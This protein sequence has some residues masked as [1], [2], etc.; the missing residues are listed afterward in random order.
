[1][2]SKSTPK[3]AALPSLRIDDLPA[4]SRALAQVIGLENLLALA[5][6]L[7]G[8]RIYIP[9]LD[10]LLRQLKYRAVRREFNGHNYLQLSLKYGYTKRWIREIVNQ[11]QKT[12]KRTDGP[13]RATKAS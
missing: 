5:R 4:E 10:S 3:S 8:Q 12:G 9:I 7:G 13:K 6:Q 11:G 1:M 2:K